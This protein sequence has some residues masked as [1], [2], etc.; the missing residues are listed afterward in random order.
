MNVE[1]QDQERLWQQLDGRLPAAARA[2]L[3]QELGRNPAL[4][5]A[6]DERRR[7]DHDRRTLLSRAARSDE[8]LAQ[9]CVEAF[10]RD[11]A[12]AAPRGRII[13]W[14]QAF[15]ILLAAAAVILLSVGVSSRMAG[16]LQWA[17]EGGSIQRG[18]DEAARLRSEGWNARAKSELQAAYRRAAAPGEASWLRGLK[19]PW[20][21]FVAAAPT[22]DGAILV[23]VSIGAPDAASP[24]QSW[25][26]VF[27]DDAALARELPGWADQ[28]VAE[29]RVAR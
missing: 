13:H 6:L 20:R 22:A 12:A 10:D 11:A 7:V 19:S 3:E 16:P 17:A 4:R 27:A 29:S 14:P 8:E 26:R 18:A 25:N 1:P 2:E 15:S 9:A 28:L 24:A 23:Q 21:W 5:S